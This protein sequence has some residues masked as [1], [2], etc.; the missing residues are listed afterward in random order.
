M[1]LAAMLGRDDPLGLDVATS[2]RRAA[3]NLLRKPIFPSDGERAHDVLG[4]ALHFLSWTDVDAYFQFLEWD[5]SPKSASGCLGGGTCGPRWWHCRTSTT[6]NS[7][8]RRYPRRRVAGSRRF[9]P[10]TCH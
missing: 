3:G 2:A 5:G 1:E 7:T 4:R 8:C 10:S 6:E 9:R